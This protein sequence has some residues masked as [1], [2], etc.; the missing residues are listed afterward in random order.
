MGADL[1]QE[2]K[3]VIFASKTLTSSQ[4][5]YAQIEKELYAIQFGYNKF[6]QLL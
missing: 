6:H 2:G 4:T 3:P 5:R 1:L